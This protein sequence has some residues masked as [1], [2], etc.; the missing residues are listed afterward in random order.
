MALG[1]GRLVQLYHYAMQR[2]NTL[3]PFHKPDHPLNGADVSALRNPT[4]AHAPN[5]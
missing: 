5:G 1:E 3:N 2:V 4:T